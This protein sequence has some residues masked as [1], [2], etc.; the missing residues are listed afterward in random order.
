MSVIDNKNTSSLQKK[1]VL[2]IFPLMF[3]YHTAISETLCNMGYRVTWWNDRASEANWYKL[4]L[5]IFP[6][7]VARFSEASFK[8]KLI[9]LDSETVSHILVIKGEGLSNQT[10]LRLKES[11][12][13]ASI[14]LYLFDGVGNLKTIHDK[15]NY[16]D[17]VSTFDPHDAELFGWTYRPLFWRNTSTPKNENNILNFDWCFIGTVHSDRHSV[18]HKLRQCYGNQFNSFVFAYF[19]SPFILFFRKLIDSTLWTAPKGTLSTKPMSA[20]DVSKVIAQSKAVLDIEHPKQHGFTMRTIETLMANK[21][22]ITTNQNII[23]SSLFHSSRIL[24][25]DRLKPEIPLEFF[26]VPFLE[27]PD[28]LKKYYS[29]EN[30]VSE[31]LSLQDSSKHNR[32]Q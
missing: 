28:Q 27:I 16:F 8:K 5:R 17:S 25:I 10:I 21:K 4:L 9:D 1:H 30:W 23:H 15:I 19:Q 12:N 13:L 14:G 24:I 32:S 3:S 6:K 20:V 2:L 29:C 7:I 11:C 22:L 31:L 18:I 26:D